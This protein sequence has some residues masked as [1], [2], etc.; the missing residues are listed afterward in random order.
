MG[1]LFKLVHTSKKPYIWGF[2]F[3]QPH[4]EMKERVWSPCCGENGPLLSKEGTCPR[5]EGCM[6]SW[7]VSRSQWAGLL[8]SAHP[9]VPK[10][11]MNVNA[12]SSW[13]Q[14]PGIWYLK[15]PALCSSS[16]F[17]NSPLDKFGF[18][19]SIYHTDFILATQPAQS[20]SHGLRSSWK[21]GLLPGARCSAFKY[22][23]ASPESR[24][25]GKIAL[26]LRTS[27]SPPVK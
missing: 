18:L 16:P 22:Q 10:K 8:T 5:F 2:F 13:S 19:S 25:L 9:C 23:L 20:L 26:L 21:E 7:M 12:N 24:A 27:V 15:L 17:P 3:F 14:T 4:L 6:V 1:F 11:D